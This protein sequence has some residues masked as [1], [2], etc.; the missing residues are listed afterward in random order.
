MSYA[1]PPDLWEYPSL[2]YR[3]KSFEFNRYH[4]EHPVVQ[5]VLCIASIPTHIL[6]SVTDKLPPSVEITDD[7]RY[8]VFTTGVVTFVNK[9]KKKPP[10]PHDRRQGQP[11]KKTGLFDYIVEEQT[12]EPWNEYVIQDGRNRSLRVRTILTDVIY[13]D[14]IV[15]PM[16]DPVLETKRIYTTVVTTKA[17]PES[18]M[19]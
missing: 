19:T 16:G 14:D 9:T 4:I 11:V 18:G 12:H 13:Y 15:D 7:N 10:T 5:G 3:T 1:Q 17:S 2:L 8:I 6:S